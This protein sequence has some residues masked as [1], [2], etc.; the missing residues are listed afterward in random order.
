MIW[1]QRTLTE[2]F[3]MLQMISALRCASSPRR[4]ALLE[5]CV[6]AATCI[7]RCDDRSLPFRFLDLARQ[8]CESSP[9]RTFPPTRGWTP[10]AAIRHNGSTS[11]VT[12]RKHASDDPATIV[13][14]ACFSPYHRGRCRPWRHIGLVALRFSSHRPG[15]RLQTTPD[16]GQESHRCCSRPK[17]P[18][19]CCWRRV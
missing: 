14:S 16:R 15:R 17:K 7:Q 4:A 8:L 18:P 9:P 19:M 5:R 6:E 13:T 10:C 3:S 11:P 2:P 12:L 1:W